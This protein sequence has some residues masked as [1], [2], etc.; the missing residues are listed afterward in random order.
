MTLFGKRQ[1]RVE[2]AALLTGRGRFV[3]DIGYPGMLHVAIVRSTAARAAISVDAEAARGLEGVAAVI[4]AEDLPAAARI[5]PDGHP[6][7]TLPDPAEAPVLA[8]GEVRYVGEPIAAVVAETRYIA[9]DGAA[10][11]EVE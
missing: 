10:L 4:L 7:P 1:A 5:L 11:V 2:D 9:E 6:N 8:R 3:D